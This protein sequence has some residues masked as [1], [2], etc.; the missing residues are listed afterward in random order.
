MV[1]T[2]SVETLDG[3]C[4]YFYTGCMLGRALRTKEIQPDFC[5]NMDPYKWDITVWYRVTRNPK[6]FYGLIGYQQ[7]PRV[8]EHHKSSQI[9]WISNYLKR[10]SFIVVNK[11]KKKITITKV[12]I[13]Y[14]SNIY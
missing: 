2:I 5:E 6:E 4:L 10:I 12:Y 14:M 13:I 11:K 3:L 7:D 9:W 8:F 1:I